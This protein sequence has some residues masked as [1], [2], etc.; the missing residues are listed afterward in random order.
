MLF[1]KRFVRFFDSDAKMQ[2]GAWVRKRRFSG[3]L[4]I[5]QLAFKRK[6]LKMLADIKP[7]DC[8][9]ETLPSGV[10]HND[11]ALEKSFDENC[12]SPDSLA[13][14]SNYNFA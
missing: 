6:I 14:R 9:L 13:F 7:R 3:K 11:I 4:S 2:P 1:L 10:R 5:L 12:I 8:L